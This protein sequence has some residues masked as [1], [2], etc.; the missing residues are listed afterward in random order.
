MERRDVM[1]TVR[2]ERIKGEIKHEG[3]VSLFNLC[4]HGLV[5]RRIPMQETSTGNQ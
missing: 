4:P 1:V 2:K 5:S 3:S